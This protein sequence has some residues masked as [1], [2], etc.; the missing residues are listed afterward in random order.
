MKTASR[1]L[2]FALTVAIG[3][4]GLFKMRPKPAIPYAHLSAPVMP[5]W[6]TGDTTVLAKADIFPGKNVGVFEQKT[7]VNSWK[8]AQLLITDDSEKSSEIKILCSNS[9]EIVWSISDASLPQMP[10]KNI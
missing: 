4:C 3:G 1:I 6:L 7:D 2:F 10:L 8:S 5:V 9:K